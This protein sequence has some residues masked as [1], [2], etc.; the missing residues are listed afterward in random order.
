MSSILRETDIAKLV[1][2]FLDDNE[3][4]LSPNMFNALE[5]VAEE[6]DSQVTDLLDQIDELEVRVKELEEELEEIE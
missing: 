1:E 5:E 2:S 6:I 4:D 3:D